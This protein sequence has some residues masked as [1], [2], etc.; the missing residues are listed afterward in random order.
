MIPVF[1]SADS[2]GKWLYSEIL[3]LLVV[4]DFLAVLFKEPCFSAVIVLAFETSKENI[5]SFP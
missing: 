2:S 1:S 4:F 3:L 5:K